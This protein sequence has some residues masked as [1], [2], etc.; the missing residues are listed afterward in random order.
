MYLKES[1]FFL[2][3]PGR[4]LRE[5]HEYKYK[6][7]SLGIAVVKEYLASWL[8]RRRDDC[9][10]EVMQLVR[11]AEEV[12]RKVIKRGNT[13]ENSWYFD[14]AASILVG[15]GVVACSV[16]QSAIGEELLLAGFKAAKELPSSRLRQK[17]TQA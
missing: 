3:F 12:A 17:A 9:R 6:D 13:P 4:D 16:N 2:F 7:P 10:Q 5:R 8:S 1:S 15:I 14:E 11:E